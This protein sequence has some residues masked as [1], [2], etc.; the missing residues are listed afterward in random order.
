MTVNR[1]QAGV[2]N[3]NSAP[4]GSGPAGDRRECPQRCSI[5]AVSAG[6]QLKLMQLRN[7]LACVGD[8]AKFRVQRLQRDKISMRGAEFPRPAQA[9]ARQLVAHYKLAHLRLLQD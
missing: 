5:T 8:A 6:K 9:P 3:G 2:V 4:P 7:S 1:H